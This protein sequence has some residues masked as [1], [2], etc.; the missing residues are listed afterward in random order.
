MLKKVHMLGSNMTVCWSIK[1]KVLLVL[2]TAKRLANQVTPTCAHIVYP[3]AMP[4][5][6]CLLE[7]HDNLF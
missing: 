6:L 7:D 5:G 4:T 1:D 3:V 2:H